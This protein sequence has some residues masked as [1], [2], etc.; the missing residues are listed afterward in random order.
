MCTFNAVGGEEN[1]VLG[2]Q[3]VVIREVRGT[4]LRLRFSCEG[5]VV[6]LTREKRDIEQKRANNIECTDEINLAQIHLAAMSGDNTQ[7]SR[8]SVSTFH[9]NQISSH[10]LLSI[11]A[12]L[13]AIT[14]NQGLL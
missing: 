5:G 1:N 4:R 10:H 7:V 13:L 3:G 2:L 6:H 11:D 8:D 12:H 14:Y 9:F